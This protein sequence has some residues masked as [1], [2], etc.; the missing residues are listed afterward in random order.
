MAGAPSVR[1]QGLSDVGRRS[2]VQSS[3]HRVPERGPV[4]VIRFWQAFR[5]YKHG[6]ERALRAAEAELAEAVGVPLRAGA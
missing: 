4:Q 2:R 1:G 3:G 6:K 5:D